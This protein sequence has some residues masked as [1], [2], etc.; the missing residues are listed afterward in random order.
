M[1]IDLPDTTVSRIAKALVSV[2][3]EGGAVALGRVLTLII[4]V[5]HGAEEE[6]IEAANDASREHPMRVIVL[7]SDPHGPDAGAEPRLDAEIRVGGDAGAS[8]VIVLRAYGAAGNNSESLVTGLLL[9]DAPVVAWW[10]RDTPT[11]PSRSSI[12]R[13]AQRRI[14]D[15]ATQPD[16]EAWV[17]GLGDHYTPGD[18]DLAWTRVTRWREQLAAVLDQPPYEPVTAV[19]VRGAADSPSTAFLAAWL[20]LALDAPVDWEYVDPAEWSHGIKSVRLIRPSG[21][22]LLERP[23]SGVAVLTQPGQPSHELAFPRRT[24]RECLAEELRS[25]DPD[26]LYGR[27][28]THGWA[29]LGRGGEDG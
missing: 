1:I 5:G 19:Q 17:A 29:L 22:T 27:V 18:T 8:E 4:V 13:I 16:P 25:L 15:A 2:R 3:E 7:M 6:V 12:G 10:P 26:L 21:D 14:T 23:Q 20:R 28:I 9:P 24:L 11:Q